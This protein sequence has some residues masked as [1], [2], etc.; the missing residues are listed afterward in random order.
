[1]HKYDEAIKDAD[2]CLRLDPSFIKGYHRRGT[3]YLLAG[4][5]VEAIKDFEKILETNDLQDVKELLD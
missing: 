5:Y 3:A 4:K 2:D 1:L